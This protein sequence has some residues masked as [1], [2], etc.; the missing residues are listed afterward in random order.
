MHAEW[1]AR[2]G[3]HDRL[4]PAFEAHA[5]PLVTLAE[6]WWAEWRSH[7]QLKKAH[8]DTWGK[9]HARA[10]SKSSPW[11]FALGPNA[12]SILSAARIGWYFEAADVLVTDKQ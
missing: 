9:L 1:V 6:A 8:D 10:D 2:D 4:D 12:A 3:S 11:S 7:D 5:S